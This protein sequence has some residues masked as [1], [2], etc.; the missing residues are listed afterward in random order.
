VNSLKY[1]SGYAPELQQQIQQMIEQDMLPNY[2]QLEFEMRLYLAQLE[3]TG[4]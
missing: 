2:H 3:E 4:R 1:L